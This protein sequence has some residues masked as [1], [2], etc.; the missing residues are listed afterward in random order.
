L[1]EVCK[2]SVQGANERALVAGHSAVQGEVIGDVIAE[3]LRGYV[4][5]LDDLLFLF[6][7]K[8]RRGQNKFSLVT[9]VIEG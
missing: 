5:T 7:D 6:Q 2:R 9:H 4:K 3:K 1:A 8:I